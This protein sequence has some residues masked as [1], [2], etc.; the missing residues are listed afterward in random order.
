MI[1][2][3]FTALGVPKKAYLSE[4]EAIQSMFWL[5]SFLE[6]YECSFCGKWHL[7]SV[8]GIERGK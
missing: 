4:E 5:D 3:H 6:A 7:G 2:E 8:E 1:R